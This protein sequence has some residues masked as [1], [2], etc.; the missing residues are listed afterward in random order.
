MNIDIKAKE[1]KPVRHTYSHIARR[2]GVDK[3]ASRYQEATYDVQAT[4]NFHY[5]P[6]WQP[7]KE[8][9]DPARTAIV[10]E[11][12]YQFLDPR[13]LYYGNYCM[14]RA[15]QQDSAD[16]NF[17]FVEKRGL[18]NLL[19]EEVKTSIQRHVVPLR[20]YEWGANMNNYQICAMGY[21]TAIT[22]PASFHA[23]DRLGNA[24]YITRIG[25]ALAEN[26]TAIIDTGL[27]NWMEAAEWQGLRRLVEDSFVVEDWFELFVAQNLAM[28]GLVHPLFFERYEQQLAIQGASSYSMLTEFIVDWYGESSRWVDKQIKVACSESEANRA[29]VSGWYK[30]WRDA[31]QE[32]LKPLAASMLEDGEAVLQELVETMDARGKKAGIEV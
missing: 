20:H 8:L 6:T 7:D 28:D 1:I 25:L 27:N 12:W 23:S 32:A 13:Q 5:R 15:K 3:P 19:P 30:E 17:K 11:D 10:M 9:Y 29:L 22:A 14:V 24:Q 26:D 2:L 18:L 21:G 31:A 16:Q 4:E